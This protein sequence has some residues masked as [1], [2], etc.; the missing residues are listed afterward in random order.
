MDELYKNRLQPT[1]ASMEGSQILRIV[2]QVRELESEGISICN[3]T[4]GDFQPSQFSIP[5]GFSDQVLASYQ[6]KETNYPP[7][8]GVQP[9]REAIA[10]MYRNDL[11]IECDASW[12]CIASG[13][14]PPIYAAWRM[15][16]APNEQSV[17]FL[18]AWNIGYYAHLNQSDHR[19]LPT[20]AESNFHP[21]VDQV[22]AILGQTQ[23][24]ILNTPLN[25][26]GTMIG[27]DV[28]TGICEAIVRENAHRKGRPVMLMYDHVYWMLTHG[29]NVHYTPSQLVPEVAPY[30]V[31]IDAFSKNFTGT[32]LRVG[33]AVLPPL[34]QPKMA[35]L[36]AHM[37]AWASQPEQHATAWMLRNT[38]LRKSYNQQLCQG[39][40]ERLDALYQCVCALQAKGYPI[41]AIPPQGAIYLSVCFDLIGKGFSSNEEIR[42]WILQEAQVAIVPF[43]AFD[44]PENSGW[45][46]LSVGTVSV[47]ELQEAMHRI[48]KVLQ[49]RSL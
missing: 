26:T 40:K 21:T 42:S 33:W 11:G 36:L 45:F 15:F 5:E 39:V 9:L 46:R 20:T 44:M 7:S 28:L 16:V 19:F 48:E 32:G 27:K 10:E 49:H 25:P 14:R 6:R 35:T 17:S 37:G 24:L 8:S 13:A 41:Y 23:L 12:V 1:I 38:E 22:E 47:A 4:I 34:L 43:Q 29:E 30:V 2:A 18:P 3:L 31:Y